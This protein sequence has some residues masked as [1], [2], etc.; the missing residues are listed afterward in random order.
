MITRKYAAFDGRLVMLGFGAV[1]QGTLPLL[2]RHVDLAPS[3]VTILTA[4]PEGAAI[5]REY[6]VNFRCEAVTR[7]NFRTLL[8]EVLAAGDFLFN[9][10]VNVSSVDCLDHCQRRGILYL[11]ACLEPWAGGHENSGLTPAERSNYAQREAALALRRDFPAGPTA[12][13]T[14]GAN[15]GLVSHLL[16]KALLNLAEDTGVDGAAPTTR[17][18][19]ARL[20]MAL[21]IKVVHVAER[22][23]QRSRRRKAAG[24]FVNTWS[25]EAFAGESLQ[26][27]ELGWGT[28]ERHWPHDA[29]DFGFGCGAS[30]YLDRPGAV[31]RVRTWTP[32]SGPFIGHLISHSESTAIADLLTVREGGRTLYRPTC[33]YAYRP[34]DD[35]ELSLLEFQDRGFRLQERSRLLRDEI[36][37]G[38][39]ELG[40]LLMGH[41]RGAYWYGSQ[42]S[43]A[44][45]RALCPLNN[46]T[47]LQ[48]NAPAV[49]AAVWALRNPQAGIREPE[50]LPHDEILALCAPYLGHVVGATTDWT[51]LEGRERLYPET[52][53]RDDPW[54]FLNFRVRD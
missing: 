26:P 27:A 34:C 2:L 31:T 13:L 16:K 12:I 7:D 41:R 3:R 24:E 53:D 40:V 5:A 48:I 18:G 6:G 45:A 25:P 42:L 50:D 37:E 47:S 19:W 38:M 8:D 32:A 51:P 17:D 1:G 28:H 43:I 9:A 44:E 46:A 11:D 30:I 22:D 33:H 54:Q 52:L 15:P 35:A 39:D 4:Q 10:S 49:A 20:A 23:T 21:G 36:E 29:V 14:H